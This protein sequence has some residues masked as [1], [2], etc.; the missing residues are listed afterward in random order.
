MEMPTVNTVIGHAMI[1]PGAQRPA[2]TNE[3]F[4][5]VIAYQA[6]MALLKRA[7]DDGLMSKEE[8]LR[9]EEKFAQ[10]YMLKSSVIY[11]VNPLINMESRA[12][13]A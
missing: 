5:R 7:R 10:K 11:R 8:Y 2:M 4:Q 6:T 12:N 3:L 13:I 9:V 1:L